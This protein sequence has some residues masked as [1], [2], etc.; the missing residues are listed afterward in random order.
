M[1][2]P[3]PFRIPRM[4]VVRPLLLWALYIGFEYF[5]YSGWHKS[6]LLTWCFALKDTVAAVVGF[7][8]FSRIV[9]PR[10]VLQGR[11]LSTALSLVAI[12]YCWALASYVLFLGFD[13]YQ[14]DPKESYIYRILDKGIWVGVF[15]WYGVSI[16]LYDFSITVMLPIFGR[17]LQFL[18][19]TSNH[20]L[21]LQ[22]EN[23]NLE[24]SFLKAQV[25][26]HFLF[27]TLNN[28]YTMVVKQDERAPDMVQH[29]SDLMHYTVYESD[30]ALVPLTKETAFLDAYLELER[31][32]YGKKVRI[33]YQKSGITDQQTITPLLFFP[34]VENAFKHGVDSSL[35]ASWVAISLAADATQLR[36][37]V[38][39]SFSPTATRREFGGVGIDNVKKRLALH[40]APTEYD[41]TITRDQEAYTYRVALTIRLTSTAPPLAR[42]ALFFPRF[43]PAQ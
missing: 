35:D 40:Y 27:N 6:P 33:T 18:L 3:L 9:L 16:G 41:L 29:L 13:Y 15:S 4:Q 1:T 42:P 30:A 36:F 12:Y 39:N 22:R 25:N 10:F 19:T 21:R 7:Y 20:T 2:Y 17:F 31:L 32:R 8:F 37:E 23:L 24:V 38:S 34:F 26:P 11:W 28:I 14:L 5:T 43:A